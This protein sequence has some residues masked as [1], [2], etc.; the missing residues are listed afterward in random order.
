M[1]DWRINR[2]ETLWITR[3]IQ[4]NG[5][6]ETLLI[7][8]DMRV[9]KVILP[10]RLQNVNAFLVNQDVDFVDCVHEQDNFEYDTADGTHQRRQSIR[11]TLLYS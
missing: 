1:T 5:Y 6:I 7:S 4:R 2:P 11:A 9:I 3:S 8:K 10:N